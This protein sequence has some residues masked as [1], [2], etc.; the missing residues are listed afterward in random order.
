MSEFKS[1]Y[2]Q[3]GLIVGRTYTRQ[4]IRIAL[5]KILDTTKVLV[6]FNYLEHHCF[7]EQANKN[8]MCENL[9]TFTIKKDFING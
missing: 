4:K 1:L 9:D 6:G 8:P 5:C 2:Q 3:T 7:I